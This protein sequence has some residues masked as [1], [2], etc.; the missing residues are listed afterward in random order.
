MPP[1]PTS[2]IK[3]GTWTM[4][5]LLAQGLPYV[6]LSHSFN[7]RAQHWEFSLINLP[8]CEVFSSH[9][10]DLFPSSMI[11]SDKP[12]LVILGAPIGGKEFCS[13]FVSKS[14]KNVA[15][16]WSQPEELGL[17]DPQVALILLSLCGA[18]FKLFI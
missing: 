1:A 11:S 6:G 17:I 16:L 15:G 14:L 5:S 2:F 4:G 8:K 9:L 3:P 10:L 7:Q 18:F 12:N 13:F